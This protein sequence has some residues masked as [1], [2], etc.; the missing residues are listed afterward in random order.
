MDSFI[1]DT[2]VSLT[3]PYCNGNLYVEYVLIEGEPVP[4]L[5]CGNCLGEAIEVNGHLVWKIFKV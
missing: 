4:M 2:V 3:C 1:S 5:H